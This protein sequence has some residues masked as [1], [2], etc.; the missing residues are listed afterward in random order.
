MRNLRALW[1]RL[2]SIVGLKHAGDDIDAELESHLQMHIDD[3]VRSGMTPEDA[4][5]KALIQLGGVEQTL[6]GSRT[7]FRDLI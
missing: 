7:R 2:L 1:I 4:R 5:R 3:N 6:L